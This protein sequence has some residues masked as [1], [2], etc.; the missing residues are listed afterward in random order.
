[1]THIT[2]RRPRI[3]AD[4]DIAT[5]EE[6]MLEWPD[7]AASL[8]AAPIFW[9]ATVTPG[10][11]PHLIPIWGAWADDAAFIEGGNT[12]WR[13]NLTEGDGATHVGVDHGGLQVMVRGTAA[14]TEVDSAV[15]QAIIECYGAKYP[16]RP[17]GTEF[18]RIEPR[19]VLAWKIDP[20]EAFS[21][22]PTEFR[23]E[24]SS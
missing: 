24:G 17:E 20:L 6:G 23:F 9:V 7:V 21:T 1:M 12:R 3:P 10:P 15:R 14:Y 19:S 11:A 22:S 18:W 13:R 16:Y 8:A 4:Y 2:R 5:G